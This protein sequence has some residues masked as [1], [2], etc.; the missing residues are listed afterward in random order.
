MLDDLSPR[1][2]IH[3]TEGETQP[4]QLSPSS[5][6]VPSQHTL[7]KAAT[8]PTLHTLIPGNCSAF[9]GKWNSG[10]GLEQLYL[11]TSVW[12]VLLYHV[13][14][15][16]RLLWAVLRKLGDCDQGWPGKAEC[17]PLILR[18][19][20]RAH[21]LSPTFGK[22]VP[23]HP[24][25]HVCGEAWVAG[26]APGGV[27][28]CIKTVLADMT[29]CVQCASRR[30]KSCTHLYTLQ[31]QSCL[32]VQRMNTNHKL[33]TSDAP[34]AWMPLTVSE[35]FYWSRVIDYWFA[36]MVMSEIMEELATTTRHR[37]FN[38]VKLNS[39]LGMSGKIREI[40][41]HF[42]VVQVKRELSVQNAL[43][44]KLMASCVTQAGSTAL[45]PRKMKQRT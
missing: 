13:Q 19:V 21:T 31:R 41:R 24:D 11:V 26:I 18:L 35:S 8:M 30:Q 36:S 39:I 42:A 25:L 17:P 40:E 37:W 2:G 32:P 38:L 16:R 43:L 9:H 15:C 27:W 34:L 28:K 7:D 23:T 33:S 22:L 10:Q 14:S 3:I 12:Q 1:P 6:H 45:W 5:I 20:F 4:L 44:S 29:W